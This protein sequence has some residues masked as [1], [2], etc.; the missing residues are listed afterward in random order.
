MAG[1]VLA[2]LSAA[3]ETPAWGLAADESAYP[4]YSTDLVVYVLFAPGYAGVPTLSD[5]RLI[6]QAKKLLLTLLPSWVSFE[7]ITQLG[8]YCDTSP[9]GWHGGTGS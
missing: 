6:A 8:F 2:P 9:L 4:Q 5:Q 1:R 3:L 7:V